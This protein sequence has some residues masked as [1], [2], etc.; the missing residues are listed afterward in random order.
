MTPDN[1]NR[2]KIRTAFNLYIVVLLR[3]SIIYTEGQRI[4]G[5]TNKTIS[6]GM[7]FILLDFSWLG[8]EHWTFDTLRDTLSSAMYDVTLDL[9]SEGRS[10]G[11]V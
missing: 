2:P 8:S 10:Q 3:Y 7:L 11:S 4:R 9:S 1:P 6:I 5:S